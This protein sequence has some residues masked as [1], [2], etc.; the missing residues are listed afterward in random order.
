M[1]PDPPAIGV[2]DPRRFARLVVASLLLLIVVAV[3]SPFPGVTELRWLQLELLT[4]AGVVGWLIVLLRPGSVDSRASVGLAV[5]LLGSAIAAPASEFPALTATA[6]WE[7]G[8]RAGTGL[9]LWRWAAVRRGRTETLAI[10]TMFGIGLATAYI[11]QVAGFWAEWL[12]L[13]GSPNA[14]SLRPGLGGGLVPLANWLGDYVVLLGPLTAVTI[15]RSAGGGRRGRLAGGAAAAVLALALVLTATRSLWLIAAV[16]IGALAL[17]SVGRLFRGVDRR[18]LVAG[19]GVVALAGLLLALRLG[20]QLARDLDEGRTSGYRTAITAAVGH[21][22]LGSGPGTYGAIRLGEDVESSGWYVYPNAHNLVLN[23]A[24]ESG[25]VGVAAVLAGAALVA[26]ALRRRWSEPGADRPVVVAAV[27]GLTMVLLHAMVDVVVDV[28]GIAGF[29]FLVAGIALARPAV[30]GSVPDRP[31]GVID[32]PKSARLAAALAIIVLV[33][34]AVPFLRTELAVADY[35]ISLEAIARGDNPRALDAA[36]AAVRE[37]PDLAPARTIEA[38]AL[39][40][41][42]RPADAIDAAR[43][44]WLRL[45]FPEDG[46]RLAVL[47]HQTGRTDEAVVLAHELAARTPTDPI[48]QLNAAALFAEAGDDPAAIRSLA[49]AMETEPWLARLDLPEPLGRL[50]PPAADLAVADHLVRGTRWAAL[51]VALSV[52][53]RDLARATVADAAGRE[54]EL[55]D[56]AQRAWDGDRTAEAS[57]D[58]AARGGEVRGDALAFAWMVASRRCDAAAAGRLSRLRVIQ[59]ADAPTAPTLL[60]QAP[61]VPSPAGFL[62]Y[63]AG[64]WHVAGADDPWPT[65]TWLYRR[66]GDLPC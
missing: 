64:V 26:V 2:M 43:D 18:R 61:D 41:L 57:L 21:P 4:I 14:L 63:P 20:P 27:A 65:G 17:P 16:V 38:L 51:G 22:L 3:G 12:F 39:D 29:A 37:A 28:P 19:A 11:L 9:L 7:A 60:G 13:G 42:G 55:L 48:V 49:L 62:R 44:A 35:A 8:T 24:A 56:L 52:G 5:A 47:L 30:A 66:E 10:V 53:A 23:T 46:L 59:L 58:A 32:R 1:Q 50:G 40:R 25:L 33:A 54:R 31:G 6:V 45:H 15:A 34:D 36:R